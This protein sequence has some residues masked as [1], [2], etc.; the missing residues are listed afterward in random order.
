[1]LTE[2]HYVTTCFAAVHVHPVMSMQP[3]V[4]AP[5]PSCCLSRC[6]AY[7]GPDTSSQTANTEHSRPRALVCFVPE[8][9]PVPEDLCAST[10][11]DCLLKTACGC[12]FSGSSS[13]AFLFTLEL[14]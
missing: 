11:Y 3:G 7:E 14:L 4:N 13:T 5:G 6:Q 10:D 9:L 12:S 1:M 2:L 8:S